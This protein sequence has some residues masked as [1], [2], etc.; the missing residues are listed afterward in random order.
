[1][2][3]GEKQLFCLHCFTCNAHLW[4]NQKTY[5]LFELQ[6]LQGILFVNCGE[7]L[8][9]AANLVFAYRCH[10]WINVHFALHTYNTCMCSSNLIQYISF[11]D[12]CTDRHIM[13]MVVSLQPPDRWS[14]QSPIACEKHEPIPLCFLYFRET[15]LPEC[16]HIHSLIK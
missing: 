5:T 15:L 7:D 8:M 4:V 14:S 10:P 12:K 13:P 9:E 6:V 2:S 11:A 1:M 16:I 3:F